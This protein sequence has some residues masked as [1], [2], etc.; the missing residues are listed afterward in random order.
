LCY[1]KAAAKTKKTRDVIIGEGFL[2]VEDMFKALQEVEFPADG[3]F[4]LEFEGNP[5][6]PVTEIKQCIDVAAKAAQKVAAS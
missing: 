4:S 1:E 5:D 6:D 3:A 2:D